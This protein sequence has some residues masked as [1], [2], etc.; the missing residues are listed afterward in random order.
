M[1]TPFTKSGT[2]G[3]I[4]S[5]LPRSNKEAILLNKNISWRSNTFILKYF[6]KI[7][8]DLYAFTGEVLQIFEKDTILL[9]H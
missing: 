2:R 8:P 4:K 6:I 7:I 5:K 9:L 3:T 1:K